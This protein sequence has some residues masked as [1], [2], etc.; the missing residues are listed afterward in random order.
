MHLLHRNT[1]HQPK[2]LPS[3]AEDSETRHPGVKVVSRSQ[4]RQCWHT[5]C[6]MAGQEGEENVPSCVYQDDVAITRKRVPILLNIGYVG[7]NMI[8]IILF[9]DLIKPD[10]GSAET[11]LCALPITSLSTTGLGWRTMG[12]T[13]CCQTYCE[14]RC[15]CSAHHDIH[16]PRQPLHP[17]RNTG[18]QVSSL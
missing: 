12:G 3:P 17:T 18:P 8:V 14:E 1:E 9:Q 16:I 4:P 7:A 10:Q 2:E 11:D 5:L 13:E 6:R 15:H